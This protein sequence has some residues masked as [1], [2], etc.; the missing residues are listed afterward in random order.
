MDIL[1]SHFSALEVVRLQTL[2][3]ALEERHR[4]DALVPGRGPR[5]DELARLIAA[6]PSLSTLTTPVEVLVAGEAG[7]R[8][9]RLVRTHVA[10]RLLPAGSAFL[11]AP[12]VCCVSPEHLVVQLAPRLTELE[13]I[14]LLSELMGAYSVAPELEDGMYQRRAAVTTREL[15]EAH[16]DGLG[17]FAGVTRVRRA[18]RRACVGSGSPR[19]TKLALRLGLNPARGGYGLDVLSMNDPLEVVRIR[20]RMRTGVRRPDILLRAPAGAM[21]NGRPLL[22]AAVEYDGK[23][24][25]SEEAHARDAERHNELT[26]IGVVEYLVTKAQYR[27]LAYMDGLVDLIRRDLG[28]PAKRRTHAEAARLRRLRLRLYQELERIDGVRWDGIRRR[29]EQA[30]AQGEDAGWDAVPVDAYGLD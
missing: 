27:D 10:P 22:G 25:A 21:R 15:I 12:G 8:R 23:D 30:Q 19:E 28:T 13:L 6:A 20:D 5:D 29:R 1:I 24:H 3:R 4:C 2:R 7:R 17:T 14:M 26:A 9:S 16:L 18:L 11:V